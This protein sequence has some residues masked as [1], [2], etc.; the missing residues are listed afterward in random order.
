MMDEDRSFIWSMTREKAR[1]KTYIFER[2]TKG[3]E[4]ERGK[5]LAVREEMS[6]GE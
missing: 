3:F 4:V 1:R 5:I 2:K 6:E